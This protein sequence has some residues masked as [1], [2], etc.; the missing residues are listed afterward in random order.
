VDAV[1]M[2]IVILWFFAAI[3]GALSIALFMAMSLALA[4]L[5]LQSN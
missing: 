5:V 1:V 2:A 4:S 3:F